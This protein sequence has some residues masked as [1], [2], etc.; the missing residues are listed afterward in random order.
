MDKQTAV[1]DHL[2]QIPVEVWRHPGKVAEVA[3]VTGASTRTVRRVRAKL[4][5]GQH[6][7]DHRIVTRAELSPRGRHVLFL[8]DVHCPYQDDA[9]LKLMRQWVDAYYPP[10][11]VIFGGDFCDFFEVSRYPKKERM[12][13]DEELERCVG[14]LLEIQSWWPDARFTFLEG[15]HEKR[16]PIY[17]QNN[18]P[19]VARLRG[20]EVPELLELEN[21]GV[22]YVQNEKLL[23]ETQKPFQIGEMHFIHGHEIMGGGIHVAHNKYMKVQDNIIMGHHHTSQQKIFRQLTKLKGAWA[24]GCMC[25]CNPSYLPLGNQ[26]VQGFALVEFDADGSGDF[27]VHNKIIVDRRVR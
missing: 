2:S 13:F 26:H 3:E 24:V 11:D 4:E 18:A 17:I 25:N 15:N 23:E 16:L 20:V 9:A 1:K 5:A 27:T 19:K 22:R 12:H 7:T 8:P 6:F 14:L 21:M 10:D